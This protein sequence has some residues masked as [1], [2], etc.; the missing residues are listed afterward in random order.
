MIQA[1][2]SL[3]LTSAL[4][5]LAYRHILWV[6]V[7]VVLWAL[8][9]FQWLMGRIHRVES[10]LYGQALAAMQ[11][12][13]TTRMRRAAVRAS[14]QKLEEIITKAR[15]TAKADVVSATDREKLT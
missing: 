8:Q 4:F 14:D 7:T 11:R 5:V 2:I 1:A 12:D 6:R 15:A 3:A 13:L 9:V 10:Y